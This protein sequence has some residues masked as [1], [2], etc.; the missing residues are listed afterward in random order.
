MNNNGFK[1]GALLGSIIGASLGMFFGARMGP[2]QK[3][4]IVRSAR[5]ATSTLMNGINS[6]WG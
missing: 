3:R 4:K 1:N 2:M 6:L 5:R